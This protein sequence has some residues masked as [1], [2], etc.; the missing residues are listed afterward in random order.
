MVSVAAD[1][2]ITVYTWHSLQLVMRKGNQGPYDTCIKP[3]CWDKCPSIIDLQPVFIRFKIQTSVAP[4]TIKT[5]TFTWHL[6]PAGTDAFDMFSNK[7]PE[8]FV[9]L[10]QA[11]LGAA[12]AATERRKRPDFASPYVL[13]DL[14]EEVFQCV[15]DEKSVSKYTDLQAKYEMP[16]KEMQFAMMRMLCVV[17]R[18]VCF[19][20]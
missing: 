15:A 12:G 9:L 4:T 11:A 16:L 3:P 8:P 18:E 13:C 2:N 7:M 19:L 20:L 17:Y 10:Q 5:S 6:R 14:M 1:L